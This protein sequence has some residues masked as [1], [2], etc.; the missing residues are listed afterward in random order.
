M[1]KSRQ[2]VL[3]GSL[4]LVILVVAAYMLVIGPRMGRASDIKDQTATLAQANDAIQTQI[5]ALD[6]QKE[7]LPEA[8]KYEEA[9]ETRF[10]PQIQQRQLFFAVR[11][12][13]DQAGLPK[14]AVSEITPTVPQIDSAGVGG[15]TLPEP[16]VDPTDPTAEPAAP[17]TPAPAAPVPAAA[18]QVASM[19]LT[20][21]VTGT[22]D[23]LV[24]FL[25]ALEAMDRSYLID[26]VQFGSSGTGV[27]GNAGGGGAYTLAVSGKMY[28]L[29][30][31]VDPTADEPQPGAGDGT[32]PTD[33][34]TPVESPTATP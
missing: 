11:K 29:P 2:T 20:L 21:A 4:L 3:L 24:K 18:G 8:R 15:V 23:Q 7:A 13:A 22:Q 10:P 34:A 33:P 6:K 30:A 25:R 1:T 16:A 14:N 5:T 26:S 19:G 12:A 27:V 31:P 28:L 32:T 17:A 9:L